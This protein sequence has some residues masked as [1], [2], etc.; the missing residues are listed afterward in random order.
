MPELDVNKINEKVLLAHMVL[1]SETLMGNCCSHC[2]RS[3]D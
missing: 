2:V 3:T 1:G